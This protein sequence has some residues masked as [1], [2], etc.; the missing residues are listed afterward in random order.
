MFWPGFVQSSKVR[1]AQ[2]EKVVYVSDPA[3]QNEASDPV[4]ILGVEVVLD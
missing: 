2:E 1:E 3:E 4:V